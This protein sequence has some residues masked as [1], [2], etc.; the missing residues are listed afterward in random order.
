M[1]Q[2]PVLVV[3]GYPSTS[4]A[5]ALLG[6]DVVFVSV[7]CCSFPIPVPN[8]NLLSDSRSHLESYPRGAKKWGSV[9]CAMFGRTVV[10]GSQRFL[11]WKPFHSGCHG[12][13]E[14][15]P[16]P[17]TEL[18]RNGQTNSEHVSFSMPEVYAR[19]SACL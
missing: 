17:F 6:V 1:S 12:E 7:R 2:F 5:R 9:L 11:E 10:Q 8:Q 16:M 15:V 18:P 4:L 3:Y 14:L 19:M 13:S